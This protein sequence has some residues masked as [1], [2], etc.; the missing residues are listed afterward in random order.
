MSRVILV[1]MLPPSGATLAIGDLDPDWSGV[2]TTRGDDDPLVQLIYAAPWVV[3]IPA[4]ERHRGGRGP[5]DAYRRLKVI[6]ICW[7][8]IT[9]GVI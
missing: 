7:N 4:S 1:A 5:P 3:A 8:G 2:L 6:Y 9:E